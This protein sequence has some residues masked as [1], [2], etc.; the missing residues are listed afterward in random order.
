MV[1][2]TAEH[3][4]ELKEW[5]AKLVAARNSG[6]QTISHGDKTITYRSQADISRAIRD[7]DSE[8]AGLG[9][10]L[11]RRRIRHARLFTRRGF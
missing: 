11:Q 9:E 6:I 4:A 3:I 2:T 1:D 8:L 10:P 7:I 5:R